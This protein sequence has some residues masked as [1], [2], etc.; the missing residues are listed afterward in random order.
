MYRENRV[1][2]YQRLYQ[3]DDGKRIWM[4]VS[5]HHILYFGYAILL[6]IRNK[7]EGRD[8]NIAVVHRGGQ[9]EMDKQREPEK[10]LHLYDLLISTVNHL[11][12]SAQQILYDSLQYR[13]VGMYGL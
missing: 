4:K 9:N 8:R 2:H 1:P 11:A 12:A 3:Q 7:G 10:S 5:G 6:Y 13:L